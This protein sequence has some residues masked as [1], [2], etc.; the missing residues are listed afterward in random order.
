M[1]QYY[2]CVKADVLNDYQRFRESCSHWEERVW[3]VAF[4]SR[5]QDQLHGRHKIAIEE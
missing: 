5:I 3:L 4:V 2:H 1:Q